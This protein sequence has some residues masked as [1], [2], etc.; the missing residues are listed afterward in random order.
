M[1][2][3]ITLHVHNAILYFSLS[4]LHDFDVKMPNC[5]FYGGR[6]QAT[7]NFSFSFYTWMRSPRNQLLENS[8]TFDIFSDLAWRRLPKREFILKVTFSL[9]SPSSML[10][11][12]FDSRNRK[13]SA[14][15]EYRAVNIRLL[16]WWESCHFMCFFLIPFL[17]HPAPPP[18][19][20]SKVGLL[21]L[22]LCYCVLRRRTQSILQSAI[23]MIGSAATDHV[24]NLTDDINNGCVGQWIT[25]C[26]YT[27]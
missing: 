17:N 16:A 3:T 22:A 15:K 23:T 14:T 11:L 9:P 8:P 6:K 27:L 19:H 20:P 1:S 5:T 24:I 10:K 18:P 25:R 13:L 7:T 4:S 12:H 2:E 26:P 21:L